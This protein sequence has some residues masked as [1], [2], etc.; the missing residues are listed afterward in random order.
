MNT[1]AGSPA[2]RIAGFST[3][4]SILL[5]ILGFLSLALPFEAGIAIAT[6]VAI[7]IV[8]AGIIHLGGSFAAPTAG[9][10]LWRLLVGGAYLVA[11]VYLLIHPG[12]NL[13]SLT[14]LLAFRPVPRRGHLS[15]RNV[16]SCSRARCVWVDSLRRHRH[17]PARDPYLAELAIERG[18]GNRDAGGHQP[19]HEW[20]HA[21]DVFKGDSQRSRPRGIEK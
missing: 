17:H 21:F 8:C 13:L 6:A 2:G 4:W 15:Y 1:P 12:L 3:G 20:V 16:F 7:L 10:F 14:L 5:L 9:G 18:L 11:G 19:A